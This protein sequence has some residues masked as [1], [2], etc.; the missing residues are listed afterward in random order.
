MSR[1]LNLFFLVMLN[2]SIAILS[3][4]ISQVN[5]QKRAVK[6]DL[7][8]LSNIKYGLF[9]VDEWKRILADLLTK[10][11]E[12]FKFDTKNRKQMKKKISDFLYKVIDDLEN[13]YYEENSHGL[14][15]SWSL[16]N[17][18][19]RCLDVFGKMKRDVPVFTNQILDFIND[20]GNKKAVRS[21][22]ISKL[23]EYAD[24]TFS[25]LDYTIH[26][27]IIDKYKFGN[28]ARTL[29]FLNVRLEEFQQILNRYKYILIFLVGLT[30]VFIYSVK[31]ISKIEFALLA[32]ICFLFLLLGLL[33]PMLEID[34]RI[35]EIKMSLLGEQISFRDQVLY[36]KSKSILEVVKLMLNQGS[37]DL[38]IVG[39]LVFTFSVLFPFSK[40]VSSICLVMFPHL[41]SKKVV[42]FLVY[43]TG[44]WS[45]A[46]V[47]VV[48]I[49]MSYVGFSGILTEQLGQ[50]AELSSK[51]EILTTNKSSLQI[52]FISFFAFALLNL[53]LT[54]KLRNISSDSILEEQELEKKE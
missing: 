46:D 34:A 1:K 42:W 24:D 4:F 2:I 41:K 20:P 38:L 9:N 43:K 8:E 27:S 48:A 13:R 21:Y 12:E 10:K 15:G 36:Y 26:N 51:L 54:G 31:T 17:L 50:L 25:K 5:N 16:K 22:L 37:F 35:S 39:L 23:N 33:Q 7:I 49:F 52:G 14:L 28:K 47:M 30:T 32:S 53:L 40:L 19:A 6:E 11:I 45:M 3:V 18:G 29:S 44:K